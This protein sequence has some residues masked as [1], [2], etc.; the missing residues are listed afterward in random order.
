MYVYN[1][2]VNNELPG[3]LLQNMLSIKEALL[4]VTRVGLLYMGT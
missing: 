1:I 4:V 3:M 2:P